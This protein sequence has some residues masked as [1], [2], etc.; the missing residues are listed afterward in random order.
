MPR[1]NDDESTIYCPCTHIKAEV[2]GQMRATG[3]VASDANL[4][5]ISLWSVFSTRNKKRPLARKRQATRLTTEAAVAM[6]YSYSTST[7]TMIGG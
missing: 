2:V 4:V 6:S 7:R 5:K 3:G 1:R